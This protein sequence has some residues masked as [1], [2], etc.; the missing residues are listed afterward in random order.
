M[1][2]K[3]AALALLVSALWLGPPAS[4]ASANPFCYETGPGYEKCISSPSG[5]YFNPIYQGPKIDH[6]YIPQA[7]NTAPTPVY[8]PVPPSANGGEGPGPAD[9]RTCPQGSYV[10]PGNLNSCLAATPG[11]DYVSLATSSSNPTMATF[12][13]ATTQSGADE[14][15]VAQ[16]IAGTNST[17][18]VAAQAYHACAAFAVGANGS[19]VG[20]VGRN[21]DAAHADASK[22]A[23][24]GRVVGARCSDP[25]GN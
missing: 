25:P 22:A 2:V 14:I 21:L 7:P 8:A 24:G 17:C 19:I 20:G 16:C 11:N 1:L 5:D 4:M 13:A 15:A 18:Q 9:A 6:K 23:P 3:T 12:G 10:D